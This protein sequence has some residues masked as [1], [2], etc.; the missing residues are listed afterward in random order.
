MASITLAEASK[1]TTDLVVQG[2]I[3]NI[4]TVNPI[5]QLLPFDEIEGNSLRYN[6]EKTLGDAQ[7]LGIGGTIT[8]KG[9]A[10]Y[11]KKNA[12][13]TTFVG[14][15]EVNGLIQAQR[16]GGDQVAQQIAS[17]AKTLGRLFQRQMINGDAT[18]ADEFDGLAAIIDEI[19]TDGD[20]P[21]QEVDAASVPLTFSLL[22]DMCHQVKAKDGMVDFIQMNSKDMLTLKNLYRTL[23]GTTAE[24]VRLASGEQV[25]SYNGIPV[26]RNDWIAGPGNAIQTAANVHTNT[27]AVA[28]LVSDVYAGCFDDG[29]QKLGIAGLTS[30]ENMGIHV[31]AVGP[32]ET[33][34]EDIWRVLFYAGFV[35]YNEL[36]IAR[37]KNVAA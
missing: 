8:A 2:V 24:Y 4:V 7:Q 3:E 12:D 13:L 32:S 15:A 35:T 34:D 21:G 23:G 28:P 25:I 22:D 20:N 31:K 27:L 5:Y 1:L 10:D 17:K 16:V 11:K 14:D 26:F 18:T 33:K 36:G 19:I 29:S 6:R 37:L 30:Y 9:A